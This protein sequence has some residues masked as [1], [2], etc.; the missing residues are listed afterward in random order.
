M[1]SN[2]NS[3]WFFGIAKPRSE[4]KLTI[5]FSVFSME[6]NAKGTYHMRSEGTYPMRSEGTYPMRSEGTYPMRSEGTYHMRSEGT[7]PMRSEF[8]FKII[9]KTAPR[10]SGKSARSA[11]GI[12]GVHISKLSHT[13]RL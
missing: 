5:K 9:F 3:K 13:K 6:T 8:P 7:Y 11:V 2:E 4:T 12:P 1:D 10:G